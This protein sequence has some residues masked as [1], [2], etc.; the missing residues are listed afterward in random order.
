MKYI[1]LI[2]I[3]VLCVQV[4]GAQ[5]KI[6]AT[7]TP[8][9]TLDVQNGGGSFNFWSS[10]PVAKFNKLKLFINTE[11]FT[12]IS[13]TGV[14]LNNG[15]SMGNAGMIDFFLNTPAGT[16]SSTAF[17]IYTGVDN[18]ITYNCK[19]AGGA[20]VTITQSGTAFTI[21]F[22]SGATYV[23]TF[24]VGNGNVLLKAQSGTITGNTII[25][26]FVRAIE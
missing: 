9:A 23:L 13:T 4:L 6:G 3:S 7:G 12:D 15:N 18:G 19:A 10:L 14:N 21:V 1:S 11:S 26:Y 8:N 22:N 20:G 17:T 2:I 25:S 5:T 24:G 16:G